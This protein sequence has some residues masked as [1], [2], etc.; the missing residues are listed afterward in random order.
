MISEADLT[1][2]FESY[3]NLWS[4]GPS[5]ALPRVTQN[6]AVEMS[7]FARFFG[8]S[9]LISMS[10]FSCVP[11]DLFPRIVT[12]GYPWA[13]NDALVKW[14]LAGIFYFSLHSAMSQA[15]LTRAFKYRG[16][17]WSEFAGFFLALAN[18]AR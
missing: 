17:L 9:R 12:Q 10:P 5:G 14:Q 2:A 11:K 3:L 1:S 15:D 7:E 6:D 18:S 4:I 8:L 13:Q 16:T